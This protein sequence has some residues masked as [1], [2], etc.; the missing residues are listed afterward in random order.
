MVV[1]LAE[2][3]DVPLRERNG[4]LLAAGF[5]PVFPERALT[6]PPL[7]PVRAAVARVLTGHEPYPALAV[8]RYWT[9]LASNRAVALLLDGVAAELVRPPVNVL[10]L[11]L[12]PDGLAPRIL[13]LAEWRGHVLHRLAGQIAQTG[14]L[15]L[16]A[17]LRDL[18]G[19]P[20]PQAAAESAI[21]NEVSADGAIAVPLRLASGLGPLSFLST[22]M[23]F[24][25]PLDITVAELAIEAFFPADARTGELLPQ[26]MAAQSDPVRAT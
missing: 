2:R 1:R 11:S 12:H 23:V 6:E 5:A 25:S 21:G 18:Q 13:N 15:Q 24:G 7:E 10:R 9:L 26:L 16:A 14:D 8:D 17:L 20:P 22:T 19:F 4:L 3:L